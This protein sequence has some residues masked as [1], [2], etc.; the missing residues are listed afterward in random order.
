MVKFS[1]ALSLQRAVCGPTLLTSEASLNDYAHFRNG[2][3][4]SLFHSTCPSFLVPL[5]GRQFICFANG[6]ALW[7]PTGRSNEGFE[8]KQEQKW[9]RYNQQA[10]LKLTTICKTRDRDIKVV[11]DSVTPSSQETA[12]KIIQEIR[13]RAD[14]KICELDYSL[15]NP[16]L[17]PLRPK[18]GFS[19]RSAFE[20]LTAP[21]PELTVDSLE[22]FQIVVSPSQSDYLQF[23]VVSDCIELWRRESRQLRCVRSCS[24]RTSAFSLSITGHILRFCNRE[25]E[26]C[27]LRERDFGHAFPFG[28]V[29]QIS[30]P[31]FIKQ[32][33]SI[34]KSP[35]ES[36]WIVLASTHELFLVETTILASPSGKPVRHQRTTTLISFEYPSVWRLFST[37]SVLL[38]A[39]DMS[40]GRVLVWLTSFSAPPRRWYMPE[41]LLRNIFILSDTHWLLL[42][43]AGASPW[44]VWNLASGQNV[45]S[46]VPVAGDPHAS[47]HHAFALLDEDY[48]L[49]WPLP[50]ERN[51]FRAR[52]NP[53]APA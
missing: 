30:T 11:K 34:V 25:L 46:A 8:L 15:R 50:N 5:K 48:E 21:C 28:T 13:D 47:H 27:I 9:I 42:C 33:I 14:E 31:Y 18:L 53:I 23:Y 20:R 52:R 1:P 17:P 51:F 7:R 36:L 6:L 45:G 24:D 2:C 43:R 38:V 32:L 10:R 26:L 22:A 35:P 39:Y 49:P 29:V 4:L 12:T 40:T 37:S 41:P 3:P 19:F 44:T 16:P